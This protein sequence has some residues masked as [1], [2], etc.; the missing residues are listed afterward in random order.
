MR[1]LLCTACLFLIS[2]SICFS[3]A[4]KPILMVVPSDAWCKEHGYMTEYDNQGTKVSVPDYKKAFQSDPQLLLVISKING[5][6]AERG[7]PA[8]NMESAIKSLELEESED[9][10]LIS[11]ASSSQIAE[12][13]ID[14]L[15][16]TAKAD[17]IIQ[18]TWTLNQNGPKNS[19]SFI[20]QGLDTYTD[21]Q[22]AEAGGT[23]ASSFSADVPTLLGE[24]VISYMDAFNSTLQA[25]YD[26]MF[27]NG[28]EIVVRIKKFDAWPYD[29]ETEFERKDLA[30]AIE[31]WMRLHTQNHRFNL[32]DVTENMM[33]FE[34]VRIPVVDDA[35]VAL[36]ARGF[37]KNLQQFLSDKPYKITSK[38]VM[39][40]LGQ[41]T[42]ILGEK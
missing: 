5:M 19:I 25:H 31:E 37:V 13:P 36:D 21:K 11:K 15:K 30:S 29:L 22:I 2:F 3:Q 14:K 23:G 39:R 42:I 35:G 32:S 34:Q 18:L 10:I 8:K 24:A 1:K 6:M 40:G 4:K 16:K 17:I 20:L 28:R 12:S 27:A 26:D 33:L 41:A 38:L 9:A 7:F